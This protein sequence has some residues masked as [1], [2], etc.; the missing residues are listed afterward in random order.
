M[1]R[2]ATSIKL[3][4]C[5]FAVDMLLLGIL[6]S[7]TGASGEV[8]YLGLKGNS[9][10]GWH[11]I[12]DVYDSFRRHIGFSVLTSIFSSMV[13]VILTP[14][15]EKFS[16][17]L[18]KGN[19]YFVSVMEVLDKVGSEP[20]LLELHT[21]NDEAEKEEEDGWTEEISARSSDQLVQIHGPD[22]VKPVKKVKNLKTFYD[23]QQ[24]RKPVNIQLSQ[25]QK[26][27]D[28]DTSTYNFITEPLVKKVKN[29]KTLYDDQQAK[30]LDNIQLS[31]KQKGNDL[32][33][34]TSVRKNNRTVASCLSKDR[35]ATS[36]QKESPCRSPGGSLD[37]NRL[38]QENPQSSMLIDLNLPQQP[39][40]FPNSVFLTD[41]TNMQDDITSTQQNVFYAPNT[42]ADISVPEQPANYSIEIW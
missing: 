36:S 22:S 31:Q 9:N 10:V 21:E 35:M 27:N 19:H 18:V 39:V 24:E 16:R 6:A 41:S 2:S 20:E 32:D 34:S 7:A 37:D 42:S 11:K 40:N 8:A 14:G 23:D 30:K 25:K 28:L 15:V 29:L 33:N 12:C 3:M 38:D 17:G 13:Q 26:R 1:K 5:V 4:S